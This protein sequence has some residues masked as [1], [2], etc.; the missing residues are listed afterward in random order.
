MKMKAHYS[1]ILLCLAST[2]VLAENIIECKPI[3]QGE[4]IF[5]IINSKKFQSTFLTCVESKKY[6]GEGEI[7]APEN[8]WGLQYPTG[9]AQIR[10]VVYRWQEYMDHM[11]PINGNKV[12]RT[13]IRITNGRNE[14]EEKGYVQ[15][16]ALIMDRVSGSAALITGDIDL[17]SKNN[18]TEHYKCSSINAKF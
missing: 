9:N 5:I 6:L 16:W 11:G 1:S 12:T 10:K 3:K 13:E 14:S 7:C 4:S 17:N 2:V 18:L 8:G 15:N